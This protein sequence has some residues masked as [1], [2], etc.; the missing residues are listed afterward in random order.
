M[1]RRDFLK[2]VV[3]T[4]V[5]A[6]VLATVS[7]VTETTKK[8]RKV[9]RLLFDKEERIIGEEL[10]EF[11]S[12]QPGDIFHM[13]DLDGKP[14][15]NGTWNVCC[16]EPFPNQDGTLAVRV[17]EMSWDEPIVEHGYQVGDEVREVGRRSKY[18]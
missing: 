17:N 1:R 2:S 10:I 6:A 8:E 14:V 12:L 18:V 9:Y 4:A 16:S 13:Y 3:P 11:E 7:S 5:G 15:D